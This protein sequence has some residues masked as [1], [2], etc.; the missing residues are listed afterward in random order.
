MLPYFLS[1]IHTYNFVG[2]VSSPWRCDWISD[3]QKT[4]NLKSILPK[5]DFILLGA[6]SLIH[7]DQK[8]IIADKIA[9]VNQNLGITLF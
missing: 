8:R 2:D 9:S 4:L 1:L 7:V 6:N 5:S 3:M